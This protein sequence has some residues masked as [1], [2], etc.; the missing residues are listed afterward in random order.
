M[1]DQIGNAHMTQ[2]ENTTFTLDRYGNAN[3]ALA[4]NGGWARI[5][6]GIYL[7]TLEFTISVWVLPQQIG[8]YAR[9]IDFGPPYYIIFAFVNTLLQPYFQLWDFSGSSRVFQLISSQNV[10]LD[11]WQF[12]AITYDGKMARFYLNGQ[13]T[14]ESNSNYTLASNITRLN[15]NIGKS[16]VLTDGYSFSYLDDLRFHKRSLTQAE[17]IELMNQNQTSN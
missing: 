4:L 10:L 6:S 13:I 5:P 7:S 11:T 2:G 8:Y 16:C 17:L 15:C 1:L 3:S 9:I 14:S 12:L